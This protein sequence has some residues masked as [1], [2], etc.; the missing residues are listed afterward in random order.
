MKFGGIK[1]IGTTIDG[2][3]RLCMP[4][5]SISASPQS[6]TVS[7]KS[8]AVSFM[9]KGEHSH[10]HSGGSSC[11]LSHGHT[12][13]K[14]LRFSFRHCIADESWDAWSFGLIMGQLLLGPSV[15]L[16]PNFD[17]DLHVHMSRLF[18]FDHQSLQVR[19]L[20]SNNAKF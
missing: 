5:E 10:R 12:K 13:S 7:P 1:R 17:R 20:L 19:H 11:L 14:H 2:E 16:L 15:V 18:H 6:T 9:N 3:V 4:P 8:V